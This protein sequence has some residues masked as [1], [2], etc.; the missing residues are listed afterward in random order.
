MRTLKW[1][2]M[3]NP[4]KETTTTIAWISFPSLLPN[5]F[6]EDAVFSLVAAVGKPLQVDMATKNQTR[7]SCARVKVEVDLLREFSKRIKI[8]IKMKN[9]EVLEKWIK[10]KYDYVPK[11][12]QRDTIRN[13]VLSCAQ[14][15]IQKRK[16]DKWMGR[17]RKEN[18]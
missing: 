10:I 6:G 8:G 5:F 1:D 14:N 16:Q 11:Y 3:F 2:P 15:C 7:P 9:E 17:E 12:C 4:E 18:R 13:N